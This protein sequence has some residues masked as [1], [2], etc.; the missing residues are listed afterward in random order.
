MPFIVRESVV[1]SSSYAMIFC[2]NDGGHPV[3]SISYA[4]SVNVFLAVAVSVVVHAVASSRSVMVRCENND[5]TFDSIPFSYI[6]IYVLV[7]GVRLGV[8]LRC[9]LLFE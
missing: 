8:L 7:I 3:P 6:L 1:A 5:A 4:V 2:D 9:R